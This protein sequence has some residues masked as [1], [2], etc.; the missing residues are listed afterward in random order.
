MTDASIAGAKGAVQKSLRRHWIFEFARTPTFVV[1]A[2]IILF[3]VFC[4]IFGA[5]V[6]PVDP[7]ADSLLETLQ[8]PSADHWF[9]TDQIG[10]DVFSRVIVG[11]RD[12]L[13]IAPIATLLGTLSGTALGLVTGYFQGFVDDALSRIIEAVLALPLVI[14]ALLALV[15]LGTSNLSVIMVIGFAFAPVVARTVRSA[16]LSERGLDYVAA[17][18]L[19]GESALYI[20]FVEILPNIL[21][22]ISVE[23]TVRLGYAIFTVATLSFIGFG[24]QPPSADWGLGIAENYALIGGGF[25]WTVLFDG[26]AIVSLV[27]GVNLVADGIKEVLDA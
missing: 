1:G 21:A 27:V 20:M 7:Y 4:A 16:V 11:S 2:I 26:L 24:I 17:A 8:P 22:P 19:R 14:V 5:Y 15:A 3:W 6:V 12:I 18:R 9:G 25:W 23:A 13:T 10:R